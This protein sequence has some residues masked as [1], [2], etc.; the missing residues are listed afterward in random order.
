[1]L[2]D[3][4]KFR[5]KQVS[6][7]FILP[8]LSVL[9]S[10]CTSLRNSFRLPDLTESQES[11]VSARQPAYDTEE[12]GPASVRELPESQRK[13]P[14]PEREVVKRDKDIK[15]RIIALKDDTWRLTSGF[16]PVRQEEE[17]KKQT[18]VM[19]QAQGPAEGKI[20]YAKGKI[21]YVVLNFDQADIRGVIRVMAEFMGINYVLDPRVTGKAT[22]HTS[23]RVPVTQLMAVLTQILAM[24]NLV[25][26]RVG[27]VYKIG[28]RTERKMVPTESFFGKK[29]GDRAGDDVPVLQIV[30][31]QFL[32]ARTMQNALKPLATSR[33][34]LV[35]VPGTN[36]LII[37]DL[38]SSMNRLLNIV[39]LLDVNAFD[40]FNVKLIPVENARA[41]DLV[42]EISEIF[43]AMGY[44]V[45]GQEMLRF[46]PIPRL[47]SILVVNS[48]K[49]LASSIEEWISRLDQ[50]VTKPTQQVFVY[51][52]Q[53]GKATNIAS[54]LSSVFPEIKEVEKLAAKPP[55]G[56]PVPRRAAPPARPPR[57]TPRRPR[58]PSPDLPR[59]GAQP[60]RVEAVAGTP[61]LTGMVII[62]SDTDTNSLI[63]RT[64][65]ENYPA[66]LETIKQLDV[67]P[68]QVLIE[69]LIAEVTL[70][71]DLEL[72]VNWA[73]LRPV[74]KL[75]DIAVQLGVP[76]ASAALPI[77]TAATALGGLSFL[78]T[79]PGRTLVL[80]DF[81]ASE[82]KLKILSS[83]RILT[84]ENKTA[85]INIVTE[86]PI[87]RTDTDPNTNITRTSFEFKTAGVKVS[88]TPKINEQGFVNLDIKEELS[89]VGARASP[90][91]PPQFL[92]RQVSTS[93]VVKDGETLIIGGLISN[94]TTYAESGI[95]FLRRIPILGYLFRSTSDNRSQTELLLFITP[96]IIFNEEDARRISAEY[97]ERLQYLQKL[98]RERRRY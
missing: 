92:T 11:A 87:A 70:T 60:A 88:I 96:R 54:V 8:L 67:M 10:G 65:P 90:D 98:M 77:G 21:N 51:R 62:V 5:I 78:F 85:E 27:P 72:G 45:R 20:E 15:G 83:P 73:L 7:I 84:T 17:K 37:I 1:M 2:A 44:I 56:F 81:L 68:K 55:P 22:I 57:P 48:F 95:P 52:V 30:P 39:G 36:I 50:P 59:R 74:G 34:L 32:P 91:E 93:V 82:S 86:V 31:L 40:T 41:E 23:G 79:D 16:I 26:Q 25:I 47:N 13:M 14:A 4:R 18:L 12:I 58:A 97:N 63:I 6:L 28:P 66:I 3:N 64:A 71:D 69:V 35:P 94:Q 53:N 19:A 76:L 75:K 33:A 43:A 46:I 80:L 24:N 42:K 9:A 61:S 29:W 38:A 89:Q 49:D